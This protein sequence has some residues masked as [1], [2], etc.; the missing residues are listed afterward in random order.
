MEHREGRSG[1]EP[2]KRSIYSPRGLSRFALLGT[3]GALMSLLAG[4]AGFPA[5]WLVGP[6]LVAVFF[7][8]AAP[9]WCPMVPSSWRTAAQAIVGC[10]LAAGF[11]PETLPL[12][13]REWLPVTLAVGGTLGLSFVAGAALHRLAKVDRRTALIGTLPGA[14]SGMLAMSDS[15]GADARLVAVMQYGR[16]I[17]VVCSATL[18]ARFTGVSGS[19]G[20]SAF[21][22]S[23]AIGGDTLVQAPPA[24][25]ITTLVVGLIGAL[26]GSKL[27]LPAGALLG[28]LILGVAL[29]ELGVV[30]LSVPVA[31]PEM[32]YAVIG[33]YAGLLFDRES[34]GRVARLLPWLI[35]SNLLLMAACACLGVALSFLVDTDG[36]TA[37]LSTTPGG[38]DSVAILAVGSGADTSLVTA[39]QT[40]R[41][42]AV[43]V[44]GAVIGRYLS[45]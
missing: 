26:A 22:T 19:A 27:G 35:A 16:V 43:I 44:A 18:V 30:H 40:L 37:Y 11:R 33:I 9:G 29:E 6:M 1:G 25:F 42:F 24:I 14:A 20:A 7:S 10:V 4:L 41:V 12:V 2:R 5:S 13:A 15:V 36:L 21:G 31:V 23:G 3:L 8:L 38:I 28:P 32:A 39:I 45:R 34:V 17:L